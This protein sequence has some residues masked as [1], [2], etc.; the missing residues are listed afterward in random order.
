MQGETLPWVVLRTERIGRTQPHGLQGLV[1]MPA[2]RVRLTQG[3]QPA[4]RP[5]AVGSSG[6]DQHAGHRLLSPGVAGVDTFT[7]ACR[8]VA[9]LDG[10][11]PDDRMGKRVQQDVADGRVT[12]VRGRVSG[13]HANCDGLPEIACREL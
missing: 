3:D 1:Q 13:T 2:E 5:L 10:Q 7:D 12:L 8:R 11:L 9:A 6:V 4:E